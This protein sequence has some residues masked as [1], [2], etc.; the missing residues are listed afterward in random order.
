MESLYKNLVEYCKSD[1]YPFHMP[2]H[3]RNPLFFPTSLG[4]ETDITEIDGFDNLHDAREIIKQ[5]MDRTAKVFKAKDSFYLVNGSTCG[6]LAGISACTKN[7]DE[8][9]M[10]RNCHKSVYHGIYLKNLQVHYIYPHFLSSLGINGGISADN[11][12]K[13]LITHSNIKLVI[14]TSPTYEGIVSDIEGIAEVCH[15]YKIPL[16]VDE[17]HGAHLGFSS[18]F[19]KSANELGADI[20]V[21]SLHKTLPSLTQ[22]ALLHINGTLVSKDK[23]K[24]YLSIY[25]TSSPSYVFMAGIDYLTKM[26]Q[27]DG[28][29]LFLNYENKL[30]SFYREMRQL[31]K[32]FILEKK[33][34]SIC[35]D[36]DP[37]KIV[38]FTIN[39]NITGHSLYEM[40][41]EKYHL[42]MEMAASHYVIA[43]TSICDSEEG[44]IRLKNALIEIDNN[45]AKNET[46]NKGMK[47]EAFLRVFKANEKA[48]KDRIENKPVLTIY[49][50]ENLEG[51]LTSIDKSKN[52]VSKE[53]V[54]LYP[55]GIPIMIPGEIITQNIIEVMEEYKKSGLE[56]R[57]LLDSNHKSIWVVK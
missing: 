33:E 13:M 9:L 24:K 39:A 50:A 15:K 53:Y 54:Y 43:M 11:I 30:E 8:V 22:T 27:E 44:F 42:Q 28:R 31:K 29:K 34:N 32:L 35:F 55:P 14:I 4:Y 38:I 10:A 20:V 51:E 19:P 40:L 17:A 7:G 2:G 25:Q 23:I 21:E 6:L 56:M 57:G 26:L 45:I 3:K 48:A 52:K 1:Y 36:M 49:Q 46:Q 47:E 12:E 18:K 41:L 16:M 5:A 37:S